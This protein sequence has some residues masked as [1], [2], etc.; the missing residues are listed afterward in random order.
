MFEFLREDKVRPGEV[1]PGL[2]YRQH[3]ESIASFEMSNWPN[4]DGKHYQL[5]HTAVTD[6]Y[7]TRITEEAVDHGA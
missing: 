2:T 5:D 1:C 3:A 6:Y 4:Y 7:V